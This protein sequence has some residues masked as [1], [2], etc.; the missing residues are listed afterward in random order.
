MAIARL[1]VLT[2][3][4]GAPPAPPGRALAP[5]ASKNLRTLMPPALGGEVCEEWVDRL[6]KRI[7][8]NKVPFAPNP[9]LYNHALYTCT[10]IPYKN[11]L[12]LGNV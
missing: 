6:Q 11:L 9:T 7:A 4:S 12:S 5:S 1:Q 2:C 10:S 3:S 8:M